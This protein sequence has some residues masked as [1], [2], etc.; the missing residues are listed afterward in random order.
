M[1]SLAQFVL[2]TC[3]SF[4]VGNL[5]ASAGDPVRL[6]G[7]SLDLPADWAFSYDPPEVLLNVAVLPDSSLRLIRILDGKDE[8]DSLLTAHFATYKYLLQT[9]DLR[10]GAFDAILELVSVKADTAYEPQAGQPESS[11][12]LDEI[13]AFIAASRGSRNFRSPLRKPASTNLWEPYSAGFFSYRPTRE[14]EPLLIDGFYP[15]ATIHSATVPENYLPALF[16]Q[17]AILWAD[18]WGGNSYPYEV[19]LSEIEVGLGDYEHRFAKGS[20]RKGQLFDVQGLSLCFNFL[21]QGGYWLE[22]RSSLS[23]L[24][25]RL[26]APLG[27][28]KLDLGFGDFTTEL[29]VLTLRPEYW[30]PENFTVERRYRTITAA[31]RSPWLN[32]ALLNENET[33]HAAEFLRS[34]HNDALHLQAWRS[35][36]FGKLILKPLY[37]HQFSRRDFDLARQ[38]YADLAALE[39]AY[40]LGPLQAKTRTELRDFRRP[41]FHGAVSWRAKEAE[42]GARARLEDDDRALETQTGN[43][44]SAA[45]TLRRVDSREPADFSVFIRWP[46][47]SGFK[48][49]LALGRKQVENSAEQNTIAKETQTIVEPVN[50]LRLGGEIDH[51]WDKWNLTWQPGLT[52]QGGYSQLREEPRFRYQSHLTLTR[53][54]THGNAL[55]AGFALLGH[56]HYNAA[57]TPQFSVEKALAADLWAGVRIG[58]RFEFQVNYQNITDSSIYAVYPVPASLHATL[59]WFYLN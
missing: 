19:T 15:N 58:N 40:T 36:A 38:S 3:L 32:L 26:S 33:T 7:K 39:L 42:L 5:A 30:R 13:E 51:N 27:K 53:L 20:L 55:Y 45:D 48:F 28:T 44:Y 2:L 57:T 10:A 16:D 56:S 34:L 47:S 4:C 37:E 24:L 59:R 54:L 50:Y 43:I 6:G 25:F 9:D 11:S 49:S 35:F 29:S 17:L 21:T 23:S 14:D 46:L 41:A 52:L 8:L 18:A 22:E 1:K 12:R 31:W